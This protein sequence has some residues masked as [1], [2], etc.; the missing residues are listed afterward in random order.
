MENAWL[1]T[2]VTF[3]NEFY[4]LAEACGVNYWAARELWSEDPE[5]PR[6]IRLSDGGSAGSVGDISPRT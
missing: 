5:S 2:Q 6:R 4:D 3:A 1:A